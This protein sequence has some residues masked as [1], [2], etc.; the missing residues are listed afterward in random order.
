MLAVPAV[1][2][3]QDGRISHVICN[4]HVLWLERIIFLHATRVA[5]HIQD[6]TQYGAIN[7]TGI[8]LEKWFLLGRA[9]D[10]VDSWFT[11]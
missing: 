1:K 7:E 8:V 6:L 10:D 3:S 2:H 9:G 11:L 5:R 4:L